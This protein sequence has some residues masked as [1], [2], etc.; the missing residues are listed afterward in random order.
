MIEK[1][2]NELLKLVLAYHRRGKSIIPIGRG[3]T[4]RDLNG[5]GTRVKPP[6]KRYAEYLTK[7]VANRRNRNSKAGCSPAMTTHVNSA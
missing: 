4:Q 1:T 7:K 2:K 6:R 5:K 3:K